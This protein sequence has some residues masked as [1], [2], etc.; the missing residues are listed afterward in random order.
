MSMAEIIDELPKLSHQQR[1]ELC[2]RIIALEAE[3]E[4]LAAADYSAREGCAILDAM[5]AEDEAHAR[6]TAQG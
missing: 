1:L 6:G 3:Q 2:Q 4:D 5:E